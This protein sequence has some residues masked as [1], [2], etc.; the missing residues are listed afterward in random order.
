MGPPLRPR[1]FCR[2]LHCAD[3]RASGA[4]DSNRTLLC[5]VKRFC[6]E[7]ITKVARL[8]APISKNEEAPEWPH[9]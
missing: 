7:S 4:D 3:V 8:Q 9:E 2:V 6:A 5:A 1:Q